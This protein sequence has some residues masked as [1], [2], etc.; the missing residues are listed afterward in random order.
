[1]ER[2]LLLRLGQ[3]RGDT[4]EEKSYSGAHMLPKNKR[5]AGKSSSDCHVQTAEPFVV[6]GNETVATNS[7]A[8][9]GKR[10]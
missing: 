8:V 4:Q 3:D 10:K 1:M 7:R 2:C 6:E 9:R 5:Y